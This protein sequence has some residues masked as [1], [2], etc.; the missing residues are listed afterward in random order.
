MVKVGHLEFLFVE[1]FCVKKTLFICEIYEP[2][3]AMFTKRAC[4]M[5][6]NIF[7]WVSLLTGIWL[8]VTDV[9]EFSSVASL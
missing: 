2:G 3:F 7:R 6:E 9:V 5:N 8:G 4:I 1:G